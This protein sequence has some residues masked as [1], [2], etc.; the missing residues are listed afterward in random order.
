MIFFFR[1]IRSPSSSRAPRRGGAAFLTFGAFQNFRRN[2]LYN[3]AEFPIIIQKLRVIQ[4]LLNASTFG[5][6]QLALKFCNFLLQGSVFS[7]CV[8]KSD[9]VLVK[10]RLHPLHAGDKPFQQGFNFLQLALGI[11]HVC[12][13]HNRFDF[14]A[15]LGKMGYF[16]ENTRRNMLTGGLI[17]TFAAFKIRILADH[18]RP[19][20][21]LPLA[22]FSLVADDLFGTQTVIFRQ[23]NERDVHVR[24]FLVE[25]HDGGHKGFRTLFLPQKFKRMFKIFFNLLLRLVLEETGRTGNQDF[26]QLQLNNGFPSK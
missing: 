9:L 24:G 14:P 10:L 22:Q 17:G 20:I 3:S 5:G 13:I 7:S 18:V 12:V 23:R 1:A 8:R 2:P 11:E 6:I 16:F 4:F 21:A 19:I 26:D 25:M 15:L